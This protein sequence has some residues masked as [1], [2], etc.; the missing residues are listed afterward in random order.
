M[1]LR[2]SFEASEVL[3]VGAANILEETAELESESKDLNGTSS[4][5]AVEES[6]P[7]MR[8]PGR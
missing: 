6:P 7:A 8:S 1:H 5:R 3:A 4:R 2:D